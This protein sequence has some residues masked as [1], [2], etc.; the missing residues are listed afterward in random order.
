MISRITRRLAAVALAFLVV[1]GAAGAATGHSQLIDS[2]PKADQTL[3]E[4]P[5]DVELE[6]NEEVDERGAVVMVVDADDENR[7]AGDVVVDGRFVR[8][9]LADDLPDGGYEIRWRV[10]SADGHPVS[11]SVP[12]SVGDVDRT[13]DGDDSG[14]PSLVV[15]VTVGAII[16]LAAI[17]LIVGGRRRKA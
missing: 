5:A 14:G 12:F 7:T 15:G 10:V 11:G 3:T 1:L 13:E 2:T 17:W 16:L 6:F 4:A 8:V 9:R